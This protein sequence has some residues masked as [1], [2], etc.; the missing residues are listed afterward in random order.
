MI[1]L[2]G[3][4]RHPEDDL[5]LLLEHLSPDVALDILRLIDRVCRLEMR[6]LRLRER[7]ASISDAFR[8]YS[9]QS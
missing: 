3:P 1:R 4:P 6:L 9:R 2:A 7:D 5:A 8:R